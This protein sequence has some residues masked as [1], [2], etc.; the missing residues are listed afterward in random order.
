VNFFANFS[1]LF[2]QALEPIMEKMLVFSSLMSPSI[3]SVLG[4]FFIF[5][6]CSG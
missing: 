3:Y 1:P 2:E 4:G 6:N 5:F